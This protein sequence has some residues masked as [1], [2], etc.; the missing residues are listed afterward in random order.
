MTGGAGCLKR[1][2]KCVRSAL[3]IP[4]SR[5]RAPRN[6]GR[7][8]HLLLPGRRLALAL[9]QPLL[10]LGAVAA[11]EAAGGGTEHAVMAGIVTG[12]AADHGA[13]QAALGVG[14]RC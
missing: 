10:L 13:F 14:R 9:L 7:A 11:V 8:S 2:A 1:E 12:N 5:L 3:K 4:G 6:D